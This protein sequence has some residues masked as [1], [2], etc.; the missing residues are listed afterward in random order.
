MDKVYLRGEEIFFNKG[1]LGWSVV[2]PMRNPDK[3]INWF[4]LLT[5]GSWW[6]LM[7]VA[8]ITF[9]LAA[10]IIE[11]TSNINILIGCFD[12]FENLEVCKRSFGYVEYTPIENLSMTLKP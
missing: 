2:H 8:V 7:G 1:L 10:A 12:S 4:N 5:G 11:Y 9:L 6:N 3:T